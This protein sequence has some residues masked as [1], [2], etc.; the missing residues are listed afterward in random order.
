[1]ISIFSDQSVWLEDANEGRGKL[2]QRISGAVSVSIKG[3]RWER[4]SRNLDASEAYVPAL[5]DPL[6]QLDVG[7][8]HSKLASALPK[9]ARLK[10]VREAHGW[11]ITVYSTSADPVRYDV[12]VA[13]LRAAKSE[14]YSLIQT[15]TAT[16]WGTFCG[17]QDVDANH[18]YVFTDEPSGSSDFLGLYVYSIEK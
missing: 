12:Q 10:A 17:V 5:C 14:D 6:N 9:G 3:S 4:V 16:R 8:T 11:A 7:S 1:M 18:Y 2:Q 13:L 15:D